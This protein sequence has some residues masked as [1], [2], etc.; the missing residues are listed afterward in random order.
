MSNTPWPPRSVYMSDVKCCFL[1][2]WVEMAK[3]PWRSWSITPIFIPALG[4]PRCI[5]GANLAIVAP[6][7]NKLSHRQAKFLRNLSQIGQNEL[8]DKGQWPLFSKPIERIPGCMFGKILLILAPIHYK[9]SH[10]Q[11]KFP[12]FFNQ[13]GQNYLEGKV[14]MTS[15]FN[16]N[17]EYPRLHVWCKFGDF[18]SNLWRVIV[19]TR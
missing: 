15:I 10:R 6:I 8:K 17:Q 13:N 1:K 3:W 12:R 4:I 9:L 19:Q 16:T 18:S 14:N 11:A 2:F 7:Y 5:F